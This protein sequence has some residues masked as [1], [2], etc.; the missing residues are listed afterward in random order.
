MVGRP[1]RRFRYDALKPQRPQIQLVD[2]D[3]DRPHRIVFSYVV[4][5]SGSKTPCVRSSP[6]TKRFI[7]NPD[8]IHQ[9]SNP[10]TVFT[11]VR[12]ETGKE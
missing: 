3:V 2:K 10:T 11:R 12:R 8:S 6:S 4:V 1:T 5:K 9:D 7:K